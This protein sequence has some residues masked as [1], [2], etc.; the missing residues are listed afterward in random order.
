MPEFVFE[1]TAKWIGGTECDLIVKG[2]RLATVSP[3]LE[4]GGK[5]GYPAPEEVFAAALASCM[6]T[7]YILVA[8]N[9]QLQLKNAETT[10]R[11]KM[12][13]EGLEKLVFTGIEFNI[14][15]ELEA[16]DERNRKKAENILRVA[17]RICPLRQSWGDKVSI[18]FKL[19]FK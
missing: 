13:V 16:D 12:S 18:T 6:N 5:A 2:E 19:T 1:G 8:R 15:V 9:S 10:A 14:G 11:I 17:E 4:F 3:P 7:I